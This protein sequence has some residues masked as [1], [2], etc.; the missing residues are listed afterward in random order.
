[1]IESMPMPMPGDPVKAEHVRTLS[2]ALRHRTPRPSATVKVVEFGDNGY[3][4][5][6]IPSGAAAPP[7]V[8]GVWDIRPDLSV[9]PGLIGGKIPRIDG[10]AINTNPA[11]VLPITGTGTEYVMFKLNF[12]IT[13]TSGYLSAYTLNTV[14]LVISSTTTPADADNDTHYLMLN[15]IIDGDWGDSY[16]DT[17]IPITLWDNGYESTLLRYGNL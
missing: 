3:C 1:M 12:T 9:V 8:Y 15:T 5:E 4:L 10:T 16:F 11:P 14:D 7:P 2:R 6:V 13:L 17:S